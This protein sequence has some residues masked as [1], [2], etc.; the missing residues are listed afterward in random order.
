MNNRTTG[1]MTSIRV[2]WSDEE[3]ENRRRVAAT[4]AQTARGVIETDP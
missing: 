1:E 4:P 2:G 3:R